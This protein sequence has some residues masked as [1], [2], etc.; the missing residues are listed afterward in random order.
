MRT[1]RL[2]KLIRHL[3]EDVSFGFSD[4]A[5]SVPYDGQT[6]GQVTT[7][8]LVAL[9]LVATRKRLSISWEL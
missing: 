1:T 5:K 2:L 9:T 6:V 7:S 3:S 8:V 4:Y